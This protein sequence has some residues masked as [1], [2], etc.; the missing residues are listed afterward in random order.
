MLDGRTVKSSYYIYMAD[1]LTKIAQGTKLSVGTKV[2]IGV[3]VL[4]VVAL[5]A[6][7]GYAVYV[8]GFSS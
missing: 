8:G 1:V 4:A 6:A 5:G 2:T 7:L 3:A